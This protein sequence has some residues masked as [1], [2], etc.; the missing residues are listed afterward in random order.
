MLTSGY[1][2][3]V[4]EVHEQLEEAV[5]NVKKND[6]LII[7]G[8]WNAV[9]GEEQEG[10]AVE[11]YGLGVRNKRGQRLIDFCKGEEFIIT[12]TI[13]EQHLRRRY[14]WVKPG[15]TT[16]YQ[17][18]CIMIKKEHKIRVQQ[19]ITYTGADKYSDHNAVVMKYQLQRKKRIYKTAL[20]NSKW[21]LDKLNEEKE[22]ENYN[23][24][25]KQNLK[26]RETE[27][28]DTNQQWENFKHAI[29][30]AAKE[31]LGILKQQP[32]KRRISE[33]KT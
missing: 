33:K 2:D 24:R 28:T 6:N 16:R 31:T 18:D 11:K 5:E 29:T 21:A 17:T 12:N 22:I 3:E 4:Q 19:S 30:R 14:T 15:H 10:G 1:K 23:N 27:T 20:N 32:R 25:I 7:L 13:F 26:Y 8:D 9:V